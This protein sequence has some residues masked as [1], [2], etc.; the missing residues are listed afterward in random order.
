MVV[1]GVEQYFGSCYLLCACRDLPSRV[2]MM[3]AHALRTLAETY[4]FC[5]L[6]SE[7]FCVSA[8]CLSGCFR[9]FV[10]PVGGF[11]GGKLGEANLEPGAGVTTPFACL[12]L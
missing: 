2:C 10:C 7:V 11:A 4:C 1:K 5:D 8:G 12:F 6:F 9:P 3:L